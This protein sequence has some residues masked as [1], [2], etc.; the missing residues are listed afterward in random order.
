MGY[1]KHNAIVV[2]AGEDDIE[3]IHQKAIEIFSK[4]D[5]KAERLIG[6]IIP[7]ITNGDASF[8]IAP[9]GSKEGWDKSDTCNDLRKELMDWLCD[10]TYVDYVEVRFGGD[11]ESESIERSKEI[12]YTRRFF[13]NNT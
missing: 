7:S 11:D 3:K 9:D 4:T 5:F 2:V 12:D 10:N 1:I 8:F 6:S 13:S